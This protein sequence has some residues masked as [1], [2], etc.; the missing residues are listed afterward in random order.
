MTAVALMMACGTAG[1]PNT[2]VAAAS[3][4]A[5]TAGSTAVVQQADAQSVLRM[6]HGYHRWKS[7]RCRC[8]RCG[9]WRDGCVR[10]RRGPRGLPG[11]KGP[12]GKQGPSG[13]RGPRGERG[14]NG[15]AGPSGAISSIDTT[16]VSL[17]FPPYD[18]NFTVYV[19]DGTTW[20]QDP[21][22]A[23][24]QA[25]HSLA[26]VPGYPDGAT[27]VSLTEAAE[28]L[29]SL[30]ITVLTSDGTLTKTKCILTAPP[31]PPGLDWGTTYCAPFTVITPPAG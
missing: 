5:Q 21:R 26:S 13:E 6:T 23:P 29:S 4:I 20:I 15:Q 19:A 18:T 14:L 7:C 11:E 22:T 30:L 27:G 9:H 25:W 28:P 10:G 1:S 12:C 31:P 24:P 17:T 3:T 8:G 16:L 2:G